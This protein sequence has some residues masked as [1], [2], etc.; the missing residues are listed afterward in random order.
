MLSAVQCV[1]SALS[2][3]AIKKKE[4]KKYYKTEM[5]CVDT[6]AKK[7]HT[8]PNKNTFTEKKRKE[9]KKNHT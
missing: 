8:S 9:K 6:F 7:T 4:K 2:I 5:A 3:K 1:Y